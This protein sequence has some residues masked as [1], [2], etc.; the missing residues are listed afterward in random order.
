[1]THARRTSLTEPQLDDPTPG[2]QKRRREEQEEE[3]IQKLFPFD[4]KL[5]G[6]LANPQDKH[7][8]LWVCVLRN[9]QMLMSQVEGFEGRLVAK[10]KTMDSHKF[11][12]L[13]REAYLDNP[14]RR[15]EGSLATEEKAKKLK[16]YEHDL[17]KAI[18]DEFS[19]ARNVHSGRIKE[20]MVS[21]ARLLPHCTAALD[22]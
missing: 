2:A 18:V 10:T 11:W 20:L 12:N 19:S 3:A 16:M 21:R 6:P 1:M 8:M 9:Q 14:L 4:G 5:Y 13:Y 15:G 7:E 22:I 17:E